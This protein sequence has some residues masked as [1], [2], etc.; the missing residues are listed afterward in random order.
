MDLTD[1][2]V[3]GHT[4][5]TSFTIYHP[6]NETWHVTSHKQRLLL[7]ANNNQYHSAFCITCTHLKGGI[8]IILI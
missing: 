5:V 8:D 6:F 4:P 3:L 7:S 1:I 2:H